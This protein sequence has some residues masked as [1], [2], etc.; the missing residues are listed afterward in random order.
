ME[1]NNSQQFLKAFQSYAS[2]VESRRGRITEAGQRFNTD[3]VQQLFQ[4]QLL[5]S[6]AMRERA[7]ATAALA[8]ALGA[9]PMAIQ[10]LKK[11]G[12]SGAK[13]L[14]ERFPET[15]QSLDEATQGIRAGV[16][17]AASAVRSGVESAATSAED[18]LTEG[19]STARSLG[20]SAL[21]TLR[22]AGRASADAV[23]RL[24]STGLEGA[25]RAGASSY[26]G[27]SRVGNLSRFGARGLARGTA[28]NLDEAS[29]GLR[30][31]GRSIDS[32]VRS[33]LSE[34]TSTTRDVAR[35]AIR[36]VRSV[37]NKTLDSLRGVGRGT[38]PSAPEPLDETI[39]P[40]G[41]AQQLGIDDN[42][43]SST[44]FMDNAPRYGRSVATIEEDT[45]TNITNEA[46]SAVGDVEMEGGQVLPPE[47][48]ATF[49]R[50][51]RMVIQENYEAEPFR[52]T[53]RPATRPVIDDYE[54][55]QDPSVR[56]VS[57]TQPTAEAPSA[58]EPDPA[59]SA[60]QENTRLST[61]QEG[62]EGEGLSAESGEAAA[63]AGGEAAGEAGAAAGEAA[64]AAAGEAAEVAGATIAST[65]LDFLGPIGILAGIVTAGVELGKALSH[66]TPDPVQEEDVNIRPSAFGRVKDNIAP[67]INTALTVGG[68][69]SAF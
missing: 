6:D 15:Y 23:G 30:S 67:S 25:S 65:A 32:N 2:Q 4:T 44:P 19:A 17:S 22:S 29:Q 34:A 21:N 45:P 20:G 62:D 5:K 64:G 39:R 46:P 51:N 8:S 38:T 48:Q 43:D 40:A 11:A 50:F 26:E 55:E 33:G 14:E 12:E 31:V 52:A 47:G 18:T 41:G 61:I 36:G 16:R 69:V 57:Q 37:G 68:G 7:E 13:L 35:D 3:N 27:L 58:T 49:G 54:G 56:P 28:Q 66:K 24:G 60:S 59:A 1:S 9:A 63:E 53:P 10:G 42:V